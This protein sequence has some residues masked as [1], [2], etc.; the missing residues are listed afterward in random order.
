MK[1]LMIGTILSLILPALGFASITNDSTTVDSS[2]DQNGL[3]LSGYVDTYYSYNFN[4]PENRSNFGSTGVGRIFDGYHNQVALGLLQAN[5]LYTTDK[6]DVVMDLVYGPNAELANFG[7]SGTSLSIKQAYISAMI[8]EKLGFTV[9]QFGT[10][11]GYELVDAPVNFNYSL[12]YLFGN[13]PFYHTGLKFNYQ[14]SENVGAMVGVLNGWDAIQDNNGGKSIAAQ[15]NIT[16]VSGLD[17][18]LNWLGGNE[19]PSEDLGDTTSY[20]HMF[21][22]TSSYQVNDELTI[23]INA[24]YGFNQ[25]D[26]QKTNWGGSALYVSYQLSEITAIGVR[27]ELFDD[28]DGTQY[29]GTSYSGYTLTGSFT[30]NDNLIIKPEIRFDQANDPIYYSGDQNNLDN[31]QLTMGIAFIARF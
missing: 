29:L 14:F 12:S 6:V 17:L 30:P 13:G 23:G 2:E 10:H 24:A 5:I 9:G 25:F 20:K 4:N 8:T 3:Q 26:T 16:P 22:L 28:S 15:L 7:N 18:Y 19:T 27:A 11:I 21:D 1:K 31:S